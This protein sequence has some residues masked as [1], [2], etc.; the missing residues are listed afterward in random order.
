MVAYIGLHESIG[1]NNLHIQTNGLDVSTIFD[2]NEVNI[3]EDI[4][5][6]DYQEFFQ[7]VL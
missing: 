1:L 7:L 3:N 4:L 2:V 6:I 5:N